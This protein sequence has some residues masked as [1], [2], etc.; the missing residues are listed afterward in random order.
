MIWHIEPPRGAITDKAEWDKLG[1][2]CKIYVV[3]VFGG[4]NTRTGK[5]GVVESLW[6]IGERSP[7]WPQDFVFTNYWFAYAYSLQRRAKNAERKRA[8]EMSDAANSYLAGI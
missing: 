7:Q 2:K 6:N 8:A 1:S 5:V 3:N 4:I